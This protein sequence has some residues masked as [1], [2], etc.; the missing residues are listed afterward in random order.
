[1]VNTIVISNQKGGIGK[2]YISAASSFILST[3]SHE[4]VEPQFA[5][6]KERVLLVDTDFQGDSTT[7]LTR[8][9]RDAFEGCSLLEAI[10]DQDATKYIHKVSETLHVLPAASN[11]ALFEQLFVENRHEIENAHKLLENTLAPVADQYDWIIIDTAPALSF[12]KMQALNVALGGTTYV[13]IPL[14][15]ETFGLDS[16]YQFADTLEAVNDS[17][18]PDLSL[19]GIVPVLTDNMSIDKNVVAKAKASFDGKIFE[20]VIRRR[21]ELKKM[22]ENGLSEKYAKQRMALQDFYAFVKE[23]KERV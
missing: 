8:Q 5:R 11:L 7:F 12:M 9:E 15:T 6:T 23:V 19:L 3:D 1:M 22:A 21:S 18:N 16:V 2:S 10:D 4:R 20:T 14:Q 17:T 13:I